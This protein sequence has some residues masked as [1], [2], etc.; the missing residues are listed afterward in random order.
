MLARISA[1]RAAARELDADMA[2]ATQVARAGQ[3]QIAEP[4]QARPAC[5]AARPSATASRVISARPRVISAASALWPRPRPSTTPAAIAMM[6]FRAP[7]IS[8]PTTSALPYNRSAAERNSCL[9]VF[10][11]AR[12]RRRDDHRRRQ[13]ARELQRRSW[14][15]TAPRSQP[16]GSSDAI[17]SDIRSS[18]SCFEPLGRAHDQRVGA[19]RGGAAC[20]STC[21]S[22][23]D[24]TART[25][26]RVISERRWQRIRRRQR[27]GKVDVRQVDG[28]G[29][30]R[31]MSA[32]SAAS[33][34]HKRHLVSEARQM[35]RER[36]A[37][38]SRSDY[39]NA[40]ND[41]PP[42]Q[43]LDAEA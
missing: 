1:S 22:P 36:R 24:G 27:V 10:D 28:V 41:D 5:R 31:R 18:V 2:I 29:A 16:V 42:L 43:S 11:G 20:R 7:P 40:L 15:R 23:C 38:A 9:H 6:F 33:R 17:T 19:T 39:R 26:T 35:N 13:L 14:D 34:P 21:R 8:T 4:G 12:G 32:T 3:H 25:T 30:P 37:P